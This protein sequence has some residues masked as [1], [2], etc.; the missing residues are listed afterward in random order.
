M[1]RFNHNTLLLLCLL[2]ALPL[3][4]AAQQTLQ[5]ATKTVEKTFA[6]KPGQSLQLDGEKATVELHAGSS[7]QIRVVARLTAKHRDRAVAQQELEYWQLVAEKHGKSV[8]V[9]NYLALP[10]PGQKPTG[11]LSVRYELTVPPHCAVAIKNRFGPVTIVGLQASLDFSGEFSALTVE[12]PT[13]DLTIR[14]DYGDVVLR[15][16]KGEVALQANRSDVTLDNCRGKA[17]IQ[18]KYNRVIVHGAA[19][20]LVLRV[21]AE[22]ADVELPAVPGGQSRYD[23]RVRNGQLNLPAGHRFRMENQPGIQHA[24]FDG[25]GTSS[26]FRFDV[27]AWYGNV[28]V[29]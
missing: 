9:R 3:T 23:L 29:R 2:A 20:D 19:G 6:W 12:N 27:E 25:T 17:V 18:A 4:A 16:S 8:Y 1:I 24:V 11:N 13:G 22:N 5:V 15:N 28:T 10:S 7:A 14:S 26:S 21:R